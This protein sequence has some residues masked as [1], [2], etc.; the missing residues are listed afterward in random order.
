MKRL[1][2]YKDEEALDLMAD[3]LEPFVT[4]LGD[5]EFANEYR[6]GKTLAAVRVAIKKHKGEVMDILAR[7]DNTPREQYHCDIL[8]LPMRLLDILNDENLKEVFTSQ[9][10]TI[11]Q[12]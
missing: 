9:V 8:T 2:E 11:T 7:M 1:S 3:L 5:E 12:G 6:S 10:Q 4:I